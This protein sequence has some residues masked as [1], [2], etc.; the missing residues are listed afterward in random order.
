MLRS[1]DVV[2]PL[3]RTVSDDVVETL[4]SR[5]AQIC[6]HV[7]LNPMDPYSVN[8]VVGG[9]RLGLEAVVNAALRSAYE[10]HDLS[11]PHLK[12]VAPHF[13]V[14]HK[15][16]L[17]TVRRL[18]PGDLQHVL[19][20]VWVYPKNMHDDID[21][22]EIDE[23]GIR[24]VKTTS[25]RSEEVRTIEGR[26]PM[27]VD[28]TEGHGS[29]LKAFQLAKYVTHLFEGSAGTSDDVREL[30]HSLVSSYSKVRPRT[31]RIGQKLAGAR[32]IM[33]LV[34][35]GRTALCVPESMK[36]WK[37]IIPRLHIPSTTPLRLFSAVEKIIQ[38]PPWGCHYVDAWREVA[39]EADAE[40]GRIQAGVDPAGIY[41]SRS[42]GPL[43][44]CVCRGCGRQIPFVV[45]RKH[46]TSGWLVCLQCS[47]LSHAQLVHAQA[48]QLRPRIDA[49]VLYHINKDYNRRAL[50]GPFTDEYRRY[51]IAQQRRLLA[52]YKTVVLDSSSMP[53][54]AW[55]DAYCTMFP[56]GVLD[57]GT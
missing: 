52:P 15:R 8:T 2:L 31:E 17:V 46:S 37:G 34:G 32:R 16:F 22:P 45:T 23:E 53:V 13:A 29:L 50:R 18:D 7:L 30:M 42:L 43:D 48:E 4:A 19:T 33:V 14:E 9:G 21:I 3:P 40:V 20:K 49:A 44:L 26:L 41:P 47:R 39:V 36:R 10:E 28:G 6:D 5:V 24:W 1:Q 12:L 38:R 27:G 51:V 57:R 25:A 54:V 11:G 56:W 35:T 55:E